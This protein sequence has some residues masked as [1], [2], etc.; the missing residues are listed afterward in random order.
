MPLQTVVAGECD[1][2][3]DLRQTKLYVAGGYCNDGMA[4]RILILDCYLQ[5]AAR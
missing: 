2:V 1:F 4:R 3:R 5:C